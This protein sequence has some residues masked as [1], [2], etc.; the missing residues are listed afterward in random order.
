MSV[1]DAPRTASTGPAGNA[2]TLGDMPDDELRHYGQELGL[3]VPR[4]VPRGELIRRVRERQELLLQLD[5]D[6]LLDV[7]VWARRPV[8]QSASKEALARAIAHVERGGYESLSLRGLRALAALRGVAITETETV[9]TLARKLRKAEGLKQRLNRWR[10][11]MVGTA[12]S[13]L[14]EGEA[15]SDKAYQFLPEDE[16]TRK[17]SLRHEIED[18]GIMGGLASRLRGAADDYLREKMDE[19]EQ[20]IDRKLDEIDRRMSEWRD[21]EIANRLKIIR[22]TLIA[23]VLFALLSLGYHLVTR[24]SPVEPASPAAQSGRPGSSEHQAMGR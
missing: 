7:V 17:V 5:R 23:S 16:A 4:D 15:E 22:I 20:R 18:R 14:I 8:R 10:R 6:A 9:E 12:L 11:K 21:R 24:S 3:D 13:S 2:R 19:I 1:M